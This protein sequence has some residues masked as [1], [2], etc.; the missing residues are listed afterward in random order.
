MGEEVLSTNAGAAHVLRR[1]RILLR[2]EFDG[3]PVERAEFFLD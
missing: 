3:L 1:G 2:E